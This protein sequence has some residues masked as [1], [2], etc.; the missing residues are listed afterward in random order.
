MNNKILMESI[1]FCTGKAQ[2]N[3][4]RKWY[5]TIDNINVYC[6]NCC[7]EYNNLIDAIQFLFIV[8]KD[9]SCTWD[10]DFTESS[11]CYN[12]VRVSIVN[13]DVFYRYKKIKSSNTTLKTTLMVGLPEKQKYMIFIESCDKAT[14]LTVNDIIHDNIE[15]EYYGNPENFHI[16]DK[17]SYGDDLVFNSIKRNIITFSITKW[18]R[19]VDNDGVHWMMNGEPLRFTIRLMKNDREESEMNDQIEYYQKIRNDNKK[20]IVIND[21]I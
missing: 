9:Y 3:K 2:V 14:K 10:K 12:D 19:T 7:N 6:E 11:L 15:N 8:G 4:E 1:C 18:K 16:I 13:P 5:K 21:F 17:M 20:I